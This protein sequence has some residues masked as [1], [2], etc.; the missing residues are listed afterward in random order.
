MDIGL[1]LPSAQPFAAAESIVEVAVAAEGLGFDTVWFFDH[2]FTPKALDSAYPYS[3]DGAYALSPD[4]PFFE[5]LALFGVLAG[6]LRRV[7]LATGVLVPAYRHPIVL[8]KTLASIENFA[9]GRIVLGVG[10]G[11][12]RQEF[13]A[14]GVG[15]EDR[16]KRLDEYIA[17]LRVL[18]SGEPSRFEGRFYS[19]DEAGF[20]PAPR[21]PI[22]IIV[23][24]HSDRAL[25]RAA[26]KGDGWAGITGKG[27]GRGLDGLRAR[28]DVLDRYLEEAQ[29]TRDGYHV[30][31][32]SVLWFSEENDPA[33]PFT[34]P[35][36][37]IAESF[38]RAAEIGVTMVDLVV[39]GPPAVI[40]ENA[41]RFSEEV[42]PLLNR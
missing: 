13:D 37:A 2:L 30:S 18:W 16:G 35:P 22:P 8:A 17:A 41:Q 42:V 26:T 1:H 27:Q 38:A 4:D 11:W 24:G 14:V 23:G 12:M 21:S 15:Y 40:V 3:K 32:Q 29:R 28:I 19:W 5:P 33:L 20:L 6:R 39:F 25:K 9:P 7:K 36:E 31:Y 10:T 34:G